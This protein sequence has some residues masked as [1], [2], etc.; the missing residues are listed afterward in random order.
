MFPL[1]P[2]LGPRG[3]LYVAVAIAFAFPASMPHGGWQWAAE[4]ARLIGSA[5]TTW[6]AFVSNPST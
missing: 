2:V 5:L 3:R 4:V 1:F 6:K